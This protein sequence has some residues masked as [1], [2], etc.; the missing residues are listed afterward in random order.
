MA[1]VLV[2]DAERGSALAVIRSLGRRGHRVIAAACQRL[3]P[4]FYSRYTTAVVRY[5]DPTD[6]PAAAV[7]AVIEAVHRHRVDLV[8]PVC[9]E[10]LLPLSSGRHRL[11]CALALPEPAALEAVVDKLATVELARSLGVPVPETEAVASADEA[12][13][14]ARRLGWPVVVKPRRSY[15]W[16]TD[17]GRPRHHVTYALDDGGLRGA[18]ADAGDA[19]VLLQRRHEGVG[20]AVSLLVH[21]G[22]P[23][24]AF[25]HRR[26]REVPFTGGASALRVSE[27]LDTELYDMATRLLRELRW[28]GLAMVEFKTGPEGAVLMEINGR[29]WGALPLAVASGMDFPARLADLYLSGPPADQGVDARYS[30]GV[31]SRDLELEQRWIADILLHRHAPFGQVPRRREAAAVAVRLLWPGDGY[32]MLDWR[33]VRPGI[34]E[35]AKLTMKPPRQF[36]RRVRHLAPGPPANW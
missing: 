33:D 34:V 19:G 13:A 14:V 35:L 28:T 32:D 5:P 26:L 6:D 31:R 11:A 21:E 15:E 18:L 24:A 27:A 20:R 1:T 23:L 7:D 30:V 12:L 9:D 3:V 36:V 29:A 22:R 8:V 10:I 17:G 2:T 16:Q 4:G 25:Q